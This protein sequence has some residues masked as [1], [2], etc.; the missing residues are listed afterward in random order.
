MSGWA[1]TWTGGPTR[2]GGAPWPF[3]A[4]SALFTLARSSSL[5]SSSGAP[6]VATTNDYQGDDKPAGLA[7]TFDSILSDCTGTHRHTF[8]GGGE[9]VPPL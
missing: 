9:L 3:Y 2:G 4:W 5:S 6:T 1:R 7:G 8:G